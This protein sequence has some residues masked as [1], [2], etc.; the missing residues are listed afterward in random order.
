MAFSFSEFSGEKIHDTVAIWKHYQSSCQWAAKTLINRW[1]FV[2]TIYYFLHNILL[3]YFAI[4]KGITYQPTS[5]QIFFWYLYQEHQVWICLFLENAFL[6]RHP[7]PKNDI[8]FY[9][10]SVFL[11]FYNLII[12][13]FVW[14]SCIAQLCCIALLKYVALCFVTL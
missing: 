3:E 10:Q 12:I 8:W 7:L 4:T 11:L 14:S 13:H 2:N 5:L 9:Y 1:P 6:S